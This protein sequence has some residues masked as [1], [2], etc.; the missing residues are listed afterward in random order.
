MPGAVVHLLVAREVLNSLGVTDALRQS[1]FYA[2]SIA[3]DSAHAKKN[4]TRSHKAKSHFR[5][6]I[7]GIEL[8]DENNIKLM[9]KRLDTF[10]KQHSEAKNKFLYLGYGVH[11]LTD[12]HYQLTVKKEYI[13]EMS[14]VRVFVDSID[15]YKEMLDDEREVGK[16][17]LEENT[18]IEDIK[19]LLLSCKEYS[20]SPLFTDDELQKSKEWVIY[21]KLTKTSRFDETSYVSYQ[22]LMAFIDDTSTKIVGE[23]MAYMT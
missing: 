2:G 1:L 23:I 19:A 4:Y 13:E 21:N 7:K 3:P 5:T 14:K 12:L 16:R 11:I 8:F 15:F 18:A 22:R 10:M 6:G 17:L 20:I 9:Y